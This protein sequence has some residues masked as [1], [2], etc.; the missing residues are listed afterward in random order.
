MDETIDKYVIFVIRKWSTVASQSAIFTSTLSKTEITLVMFCVIF[1]IHQ[2]IKATKCNWFWVGSSG[3]MLIE[4]VSKWTVSIST[5]RCVK[6]ANL[7]DTHTHVIW[8]EIVWCWLM[9]E[10]SVSH[11]HEALL[12]LSAVL[13]TSRLS[14][15]LFVGETS[16]WRQQWTVSLLCLKIQTINVKANMAN[17]DSVFAAASSVW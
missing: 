7:L 16:Y 6:E 1:L 8:S 11:I 13:H 4:R 10:E 3:R 15:D 9:W 17:V 2:N 5:V 14:S 12:C